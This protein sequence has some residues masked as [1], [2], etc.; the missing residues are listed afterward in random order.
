[1]S[2]TRALKARIEDEYRCAK[3]ERA[4][5]EAKHLETPIRA[6][7]KQIDE[8]RGFLRALALVNSL[9]AGEQEPSL[10]GGESG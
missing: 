5:L 8:L 7:E 3:R 9:L 10:F 1:M 2:F 6:T 4:R